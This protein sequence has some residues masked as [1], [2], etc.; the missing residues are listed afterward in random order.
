MTTSTIASN[1]VLSTSRIESETTVVV[2]NAICTCT[3][4]GNDLREPLELGSTQSS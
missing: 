4:G 3:P 1:S 2:S